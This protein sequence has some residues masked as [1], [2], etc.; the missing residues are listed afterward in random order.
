VNASA[1]ENTRFGVRIDLVWLPLPEVGPDTGRLLLRRTVEPSRSAA[2]R[3]VL[4][5]ARPCTDFWISELIDEDELTDAPPVTR[6][7]V[8]PALLRGDEVDVV[9]SPVP[10][11]PLRRGELGETFPARPLFDAGLAVRVAEGVPWLAAARVGLV[12][13][14]PL[15]HHVRAAFYRHLGPLRRTAASTTASATETTP[16]P[17]DE[18]WA[19]DLLAQLRL[20]G[21]RGVR[22]G[23]HNVQV[24]RFVAEGPQV[25][26]DFEEVL[27]RATV[28]DALRRLRAEPCDDHRR[29]ELVRALAG[30][31]WM[32]RA[33]PVTL[34]VGPDRSFLRLLADVLLFDVRGLPVGD[35]ATPADRF[36][37]VVT[38][39]PE[40]EGLLRGNDRLARLLTECV[41]PSPGS[42]LNAADL[43]S[44]ALRAFRQRT[45]RWQDPH[46]PS[47]GTTRVFRFVDGLMVGEQHRQSVTTEVRTNALSAFSPRTATPAPKHRRQSAPRSTPR[48]V[49]QAEQHPRYRHEDSQRLPY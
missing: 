8:W 31:G 29:D 43:G 47:R 12:A 42:H 34:R 26:P 10:M 44:E 1:Y 33:A 46:P 21:T 38:D 16:P 19:E 9:E 14:D 6:A 41:C 4:A 18:R 27:G 3:A 37:S 22:I 28:R 20:V 13:G 45:P 32:F 30:H 11:Y 35:H 48:P 39:T 7:T 17:E 40:A 49:P 24:N 15:T 36:V 5:D 25:R 23:D 2:G